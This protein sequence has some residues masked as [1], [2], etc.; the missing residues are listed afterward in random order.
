[1]KH[2]HF[3]ILFFCLSVMMLAQSP[4]GINYQAV[5]RNSSG[6]ALI[7]APLVI[8]FTIHDGSASGISVYQE[9]HPVTTNIYG[10][11]TTIIGAGSPVTGI[12]STIGWGSGSKFLEVEV[13]DGSGFISM[14]SMEMQSVP[15]ALFAANAGGGLMGAT[16]ATGAPSTIAGPTGATG[17]TG[18][19]GP[20]GA[21]S[22]VAGPAGNTG[23]TG[24]N[25]TTGATGATGAD[26]TNITD[27][28]NGTLTITYGTSGTIITNSL[29]G[30]TGATG[31][32]GATGV[33]IAG[34]TGATGVSVLNGTGI[35]SVA[36]GTD[37]DFYINTST[38][39]LYGPKA[40]GAWPGSGVSLIGPT[41][42]TGST[43]PTG[44]ANITGTVNNL[45]KFTGATTGGNSLLVDNGTNVGIGTTN[46]LQ[47]FTLSNS[48][49][50]VLRLERSNA[51]AFDWEVVADNLGFHLNGGADGTGGT[52][53]SF[54][55]VD[56]FG[57]VGIGTNTPV[58]SALL[59]LV[60]TN[61]GLLLPRMTSAQRIAIATPA[62]GLIV[63]QT[64]APFG[65]YYFDGSV[66]QQ[67]INTTAIAPQSWSLVGNTGTIDGTNFIGTT[68]N[69]PVTIRSNNINSARLDPANSNAFFGG[70]AGNATSAVGNSAFGH[71][72]LS[73][74]TTGNFNSVVGYNALQQNTTGAH[75]TSIGGSSLQVNN[76]GNDNTAVGYGALSNNTTGNNNVSIGTTSSNYNIVGS[77]N[78]VVG[79]QAY[80]YNVA[81]TGATVFGTGAM[82]FANN[83]STPFTNYNTAI[84]NGALRGSVDPSVNTG[85]NN[86]A[87]GYYSLVVNTSGSFVTALGYEAGYGLNPNTTGDN[88]TFVGAYS[89]LGSATQR[90][91]ATAIGYNSKVD[92]DNALVLGGT[93]A[94]A[95][96]VGIGTTTPGAKLEVA[97]Q[98]KITGGAPANGAVLTSDAGG[99]A[100]WQPPSI[101]GG[102]WTKTGSFIYPTTLTDFVGI[103][104][105]SPTSQ[106]HVVGSGNMEIALE[107]GG[108]NFKTG[109]KI[110]TGLNEW[111]IGQEALATSGFRI[112]DVDASSVRFQIDQSGNVGIGTI[113]PTGKLHVQDSE[114]P[115][116]L[117]DDDGDGKTDE[118]DDVFVF[119]SN[120][121]VGIGTTT[122]SS[123]LNVALTT[124]NVEVAA[125][126]DYTNSSSVGGIKAGLHINHSSSNAS[127]ASHGI[128]SNVNNTG[129]GTSTVISVGAYAAG[130]GGEKRGLDVFATGA[131]NNIGMFVDASGGTNNYA[132]IF[133]SGNVGIGTPVPASPLHVNGAARFG[134]A[135]TTTGSQIWNNSANVNTVTINSGATTTSYTLTLPVAQGAPSSFLQNNGAGVLTWG[136]PAGLLSGGVAGTIPKWISPTAL[137]NSLISEVAT[138][139]TIAGNTNVNYAGNATRAL[140]V[141][142]TGTWGTFGTGLSVFNTTSFSASGS[143]LG[144]IGFGDGFSEYTAVIKGIRDATGAANDYPTA[145][146]FYTTLDGTNIL[147][148]ERMRIDNS[149]K[150]GIGTTTPTSL[151]TVHNPTSTQIVVSTQGTATN[152]EVDINLVTMNNA[153]GSL[154]IGT[155][156]TTKGWIIG[157]RGDGWSVVGEKNMLFNAYFNGT[158]WIQP[159]NMLPNGNVGIGTLTPSTPLDVNGTIAISGAN[160]NE[161]NRTQT[162]SANM[163]PIAYGNVNANG[164]INGGASTPNISVVWNGTNLWY[165]ITVT[166]ETIT[167]T[168]YVSMVTRIGGTTGTTYTTSALGSKL[169]VVF[170]DSG[171]FNVQNQFQ[172][173]IYKP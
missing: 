167:N 50:P 24:I 37:G 91:N 72:A 25:G 131:G 74:N 127:G 27:N 136:A 162:G 104:T 21:P 18:D 79:A 163:L 161:L 93:G 39:T 7:N 169:L 109:Y 95:V 51:A 61:K 150:V 129:A 96:N 158:S 82:Y 94:D 128:Y 73:A 62:P 105:A 14:G 19:I 125:K 26:I 134:L 36:I 112:T 102:P 85:N 68:D 12:F 20:T 28:G 47:Q 67:L 147:A 92:M 45:I 75:N 65:F 123:K 53:T 168:A 66:W 11:F 8:R 165:E 48:N 149:G 119:N 46:P 38:S 86:T 170:A 110:K 17:A 40:A 9:T 76:A 137:G 52:L 56:G 154:P 148:A 108:G 90:T 3:T 138:T 10:L 15:Y 83:T 87:L 172:F 171:G 145:L 63:Y 117:A 157:A 60:S 164:T 113:N 29:Y 135:S 118:T 30:P 153:S 44:D 57:K 115:A 70:Y 156:T 132:A 41:G 5:A 64:N 97:G 31:A 80:H 1:M 106:L 107:N 13:D 2:L 126:I 151:L 49:S 166:G 77:N 141:G 116:N 120:G 58:A 155:A 124:A 4:Q 99:L 103:G 139:V 98:I 144:S 23:A 54:L 152:S 33:G 173:M 16:G 114:I 43:G 130:N 71:Q 160:T 133:N 35:P 32:T 69:V 100:T 34:A 42:N 142:G 101:V 22:S 59:E 121:Y 88:N 111:F 159:L 55:N 78:A 84:G 89:G 122:P 6:N 140:G 143:T 81:G 146:G